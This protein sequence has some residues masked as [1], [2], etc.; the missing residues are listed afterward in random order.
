MTAPQARTRRLQAGRVGMH[1]RRCRRRPRAYQS[2]RARSR[3]G[4][5]VGRGIAHWPGQA[6]HRRATPNCQ[7]AVAYGLDNATRHRWHPLVASAG[8]SDAVTPVTHFLYR[9]PIHAYAGARMV[10][11]ASP[12]VTAS[13]RHCPFDPPA[14]C[15]VPPRPRAAQ[16]RRDAFVAY[17]GPTGRKKLCRW[18]KRCIALVPAGNNA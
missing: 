3:H 17:P 11:S 8:I 15:T 5:R 9:P 2:R 18:T 10:E 1:P 13:L 7:R 16:S 14:P 4:R 6:G 12:C